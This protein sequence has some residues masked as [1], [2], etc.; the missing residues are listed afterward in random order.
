MARRAGTTR[1]YT[2][3]ETGVYRVNKG[4]EVIPVHRIKKVPRIQKVRKVEKVRPFRVRKARRT[5]VGR[6]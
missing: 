3:N 5:K 6:R 2:I 4:D 1:D